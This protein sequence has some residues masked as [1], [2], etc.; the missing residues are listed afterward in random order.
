[1]AGDGRLALGTVAA[2][3]KKHPVSKSLAGSLYFS[4]F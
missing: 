2:C 3:I 4:V 1:M